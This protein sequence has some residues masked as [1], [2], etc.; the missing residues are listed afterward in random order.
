MRAVGSERG[1]AV[2]IEAATP[3]QLRLLLSDV[4]AFESSYDLRVAPGY[5]EFDGALAS[6]LAA[7]EGTGHGA[8]S[9]GF[10]GSGEIVGTGA[11]VKSRRTSQ[12]V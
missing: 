9:A 8:T 6:S 7:L 4:P 5:L 3:A 12:S 11:V 2:T 1:A 10:S